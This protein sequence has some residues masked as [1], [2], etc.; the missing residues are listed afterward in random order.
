MTGPGYA[1]RRAQWPQVAN[2]KPRNP[3]KPAPE[4][5]RRASTVA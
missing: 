3:A 1:F 2:R 4:A 5:Q